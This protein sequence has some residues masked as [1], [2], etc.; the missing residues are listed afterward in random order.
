MKDKTKNFDYSLYET[1]QKFKMLIIFLVI[2]VASFMLGYWTKN[3]TYEEQINRQKIEIIDLK[4][5]I[6]ILKMKEV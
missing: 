5:Q 2:F 1:E 6:H 3:E 4:E